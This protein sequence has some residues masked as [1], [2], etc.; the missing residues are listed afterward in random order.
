VIE[1]ASI[2]A[3]SNDHAVRHDHASN[4][5]VV[6]GPGARRLGESLSHKAF[7]VTHDA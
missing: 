6:V 7:V 3:P 2:F 4:W 5:H 1:L